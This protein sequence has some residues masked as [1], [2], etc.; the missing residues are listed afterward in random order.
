[1]KGIKINGEVLQRKICE[2]FMSN[3]TFADK[4]GKSRCSITAYVQEYRSPRPEDIPKMA[5]VLK[6]KPEELIRSQ[7]V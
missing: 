7:E 1:M 2:N 4:I 6:C 5:K 3:S